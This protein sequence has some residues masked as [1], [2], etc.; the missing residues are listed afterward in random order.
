MKRQIKKIK[1]L[2]VVITLFAPMEADNKMT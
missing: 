2:G 1:L